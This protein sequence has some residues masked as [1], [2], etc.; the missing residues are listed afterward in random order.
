MLRQIL[1]VV[2]GFVLWSVLWLA[3]NQA[4][5]AGGLLPEPGVVMAAPLPLLV[6][7]AGSVVF[8]LL[9]GYVAA[10]ISRSAGLKVGV[11]LGVLL[12]AVGIAVQSQYWQL[13]PLWYHLAFLVCLLPVCVAGARMRCARA[14]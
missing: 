2:G 13:M 6:L 12:L 3:L 9:A 11:I 1:A 14:A 7:F 4:L 10:A 8:S 5:A